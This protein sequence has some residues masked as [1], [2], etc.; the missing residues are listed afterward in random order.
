MKIVHHIFLILTTFMPFV[1]SA[2][3]LETLDIQSFH[4]IC[5][6]SE[7]TTIIP[8]DKIQHTVLITTIY[9]GKGVATFIKNTL[10]AAYQQLRILDTSR[11]DTLN[12]FKAVFQS[13]PSEHTIY[14]IF[15]SAFIEKDLPLPLPPIE[16][17]YS[18]ATL[19][20]N[21]PVSMQN[22]DRAEKKTMNYFFSFLFVCVEQANNFITFIS[23]KGKEN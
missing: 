23:R 21:E 16:A 2:G 20:Q 22:D 7:F 17:M 14:I 3:P 11:Y 8:E 9:A 12:A 6:A 1:S 19:K 15:D 18:F 5:G 10:N 13:M 4:Y